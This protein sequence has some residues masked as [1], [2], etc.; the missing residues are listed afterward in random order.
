[1]QD[2]KLDKLIPCVTHRMTAIIKG[3]S[4][5]F[6]NQKPTDPMQAAVPVLFTCSLPQI[7]IIISK[8]EEQEEIKDNRKDGLT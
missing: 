5:F 8:G 6:H 7:H 3:G 2:N 1:M 4:F